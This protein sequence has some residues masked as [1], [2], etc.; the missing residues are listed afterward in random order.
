MTFP[1]M[2]LLTFLMPGSAIGGAS[3][4]YTLEPLAVDHGGQHAASPKYSLDS[5]A[6]PGGAASSSSYESRSGYVGQLLDPESLPQVTFIPPASLAA[7]GGAKNFTVTSSA[8]SGFVFS[9][10]GRGGT[11]YGPTSGAPS[12]AGLYTV[13]ATPTSS[14][15]G[16]NA[17]LNFVVSGPLPAADSLTKPANHAPILISASEILANDTRLLANGTISSTGLTVTGVAAGTGNAVQLGTGADAGWILFVPSNAPSETFTYTVSDGVSSTSVTVTVNAAGFMPTFQLQMLK[18]G[19][20]TFNG[21]ITTGS[22]DFIGVPGQS[23]QIEYSTDLAEWFPAGATSTGPTGS[24][25]VFLSRSGNFAA[26]WN[27]S[28]FFRA[29]R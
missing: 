21:S 22:F 18:R 8:D 16:G 13:T 23:Y 14:W 20:V 24:F 12:M 2:A 11:T 5:S 25:T 9:Y 27:S 1:R 10:A 4:S 7:D 17:T 3:V 26:A 29:R 15:Y 6:S 28:L 19:A